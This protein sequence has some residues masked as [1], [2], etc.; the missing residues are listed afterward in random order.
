[1]GSLRSR[2]PRPTRL[3]RVTSED[4]LRPKVVMWDFT[5]AGSWG[6]ELPALMQPGGIAVSRA[7]RLLQQGRCGAGGG[8]A[9]RGAAAPGAGGGADGG[10]GAGRLRGGEAG[11]AAGGARPGLALGLAASGDLPSP[12]GECPRCRC[13]T[14]LFLC[15]WQQSCCLTG[16]KLSWQRFPSTHCHVQCSAA[17]FRKWG[18]R[19]H[20]EKS[21]IR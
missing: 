20:S 16:L 2:A 10:G 11:A 8:P 21:I 1:M 6:S 3:Q 15:A 5:L 14:L 9:R 4:S 17:A 7:A 13:C 12:G 18:S 19:C